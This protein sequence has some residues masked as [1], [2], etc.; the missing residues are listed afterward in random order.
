MTAQCCPSEETWW[1]VHDRLA[2]VA[3]ILDAD[4]RLAARADCRDGRGV[5]PA[6]TAADEQPVVHRR[7]ARRSAGRRHS[8]DAPGHRARRGPSARR[9]LAAVVRVRAAP[10]SASPGGSPRRGSTACASATTG[11]RRAEVRARR[12]SGSIS[13]SSRTSTRSAGGSRARGCGRCWSGTASAPAPRCP[14][15]DRAEATAG[16]AL[17]VPPVHDFEVA[18][19]L[20]RRPV[21]EARPAGDHRRG[22]G[23]CCGARPAGGR[24][25]A[26]SGALTRSVGRHRL[27]PR[28]ARR[29]G[30]AEPRASAAS[31]PRS[32]TAGSRCSWCTATT[33]TTAATSSSP[34]P[35]SSAT[36]LAGAGRAAGG[37]GRPGEDP[38]PHQRRHPGGDARPSSSGGCPSVAAG[39]RDPS[40]VIRVVHVVDSLAETGGAERRLVEEVVAMSDRFDASVSCGCTSATSCRT[41]SSA[42]GIPVTALGLQRP[43]GRPDVAVGGRPPARRSSAA[44]RPDVVHTHAVLRQP[45]RPAGGLAAADPGGVVVQPHRRDRPSAGPAAGRRPVG[46]AGTM[47]AIARRAARSDG[48]HFRAVSAYARDSNCEL[49]HVPPGPG[50]GRAPRAS[51]W[52]RASPAAD[53]SAFGLRGRRAAVRQRRP[54]GAGEGAA[55]ARRGVRRRPAGAARRRAGDRRRRRVRRADGAGGDRPSRSRRRRAPA[56]LAP[57]AA[58]AG[59]RRRRLRVQLPVRGLAERGAR[60]DG[61]RHP[62]RRL[63]HRAGGR[64]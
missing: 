27:R 52:R 30:L 35:A 12:C 13:R 36:I 3:A 26:R 5:R 45:R 24:S 22:R 2:P 10:R 47:H 31:W 1:F 44:W 64:S 23:R 33:T 25:A 48:V 15:R 11:W 16:V 62:G 38:W 55:P 42:A 18:R 57:D 46:E 53:R 39:R 34:G 61:G 60:G 20:D 4:G 50:H 32:S 63:R 7:A 37:R 8:T 51:T 49:F 21:L 6:A 40:G 19:R 56:R 9:R 29:S 58:G 28:R 41:D 14:T 43:A 17:I 59:R 54:D